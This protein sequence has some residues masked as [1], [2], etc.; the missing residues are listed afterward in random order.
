M[1]RRHYHRLQRHRGTAPTLG[2]HSGIDLPDIAL[3]VQTTLAYRENSRDTGGTQ[4]VTD[5]RHAAH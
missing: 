5:G 1:A 2:A 3:S 4:K